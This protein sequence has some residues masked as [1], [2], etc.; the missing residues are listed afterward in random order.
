[1]DEKS[2]WTKDIAEMLEIGTSTIR[3]WCLILE[4]DGYIFL[5][6]EQE[7]RAFV[8]KDVISLR[9][10]KELTKDKGM[11]L[12]N[13]SSVVIS[14]NNRTKE[15][16]VT[17]GVVPGYEDK[18][19]ILT[20]QIEHL[21]HRVAEQNVFNHNMEQFLKTRDHKLVEVLRE[22]ME[23]KRLLATAEENKKRKWWKFWK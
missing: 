1:M 12:E 6:D 4:K 8:E 16:T 10:F 18:I 7:R 13:A 2:Y 19:D 22:V 17:R 14:K 21:A 11:T 9:L 20:K 3:K 5:R 23:T 15:Q